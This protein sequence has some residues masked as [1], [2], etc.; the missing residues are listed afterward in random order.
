[1]S[2]LTKIAIVILLVLVLIACPVFIAQ[3]TTP[4]NYKYAY[5]QE[6]QRAL[7]A[8]QL[9]RVASWAAEKANDELKRVERDA[10]LLRN[11][12]Q[13]AID[14]LQ[15][16]LDTAKK[17]N[18]NNVEQLT[19][20]RADLGLLQKNYEAVEQRRQL[21]TAQVAALLKDNTKLQEET[22]GM[23]AQLKDAL[24]QVDRLGKVARV[25]REE[26]ASRDEMIRDHVET[27]RK[28][29]EAGAK[30]K[31][32]GEELVEPPVPPG[33]EGTVIAVSN[34]VAS[35]NI[36]SARGVKPGMKLIIFR[37]DKFVANLKIAEVDI[38]ESVGI[39]SDKKQDPAQ[40]DKVMGK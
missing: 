2:I 4:P 25:L 11:R 34:D 36:G 8:E 6:T 37:G 35:I 15:E 39:V 38:N 29:K 27:I 9:A 1:L 31:K 19:K 14:S 21:L 16:Q 3:A 12:D 40:G 23:A 24:A 28:L 10:S 26:I 7:A 18:V 13:R 32:P 22:R 17:E 20:I 5:Q 30:I 33:L